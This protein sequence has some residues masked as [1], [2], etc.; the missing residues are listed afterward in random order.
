MAR[1]K[2]TQKPSAKKPTT[3]RAQSNFFKDHPHWSA[4][5]IL[6]V[7]LLIF[8]YPIVFEGK[9]LVQPDSLTSKSYQTFINDALKSGSY[10][11]WNPYIFSGMPSFGSFL[12]PLINVVDT[13]INYV[14]KGMSA[15][16]P[17][18]PFMRIILNYVFFG[19]LTYLLMLSL[20]VNR[21]AALFA[22]ISMMFLPQ[23]VAF[24]SY[25]HNSKFLSV[26]V[27]P[28]IFWAVN[29]MLVKKNLFYFVLT[30]FAIGFQ[31]LRTHVQ[32]CYYTYMFI[33]LYMIVHFIVEYKETKQVSNILKGLGLMAGSALVALLMAS[34]LYLSVYEYSH[35]SIRG[36]GAEG[37]LSYDYASSWSFSPAEVITFFVPSFFGFGGSA[38]YWGKMP[39]TDYP[40]YAGI[41]VLFLA[42][43]A[44]VLKRDRYAIFLTIVAALS[45]I[46]SFGKHFPILYDPMFKLLPFFNK[47]RVPSM[48][49]I[50]LDF[51]LVLLAALG[52]QQLFNLRES[53][54]QK[55]AK[56]RA[57]SD[58]VSK[59]ILKGEG[60]NQTITYKKPSYSKL[61]DKKTE[62]VRKYF[63]IFGAV[64]IVITLFIILGKSTMLG[65]MADSGKGLNPA[66][67]MR[68]YEM[69]LTDAVK[70]L[71]LVG[72][73]GFAILHYVQGKMKSGLLALTI[74]VLAIADFWI[75]DFN[76]VDPKSA[77][78]EE[79]YFR[80]TAAVQYLEN[81]PGPF[82][83]FSAVDEKPA[84]WYMY[85]RIQNVSGYHAAKLRI[86][87]EFLEETGLDGNVRLPY[88]G[89]PI[90]FFLSK[91]YK[92][93][94]QDGQ[95]SIQI[96]LP[97]DIPEDRI[98]TDNN[99]LKMLNVRYITSLYPLS[100]P[101]YQLVLRSQPL[102]Y[103]N[104]SSLPRAFF[105]NEIKTIRGKE[106]I[107][108]Y[109]KSAEFDPARVAVLEEEPPFVIGPVADNTVELTSF[110]IHTIKLKA[111]AAAPSLLVLSEIYYPKGWKAYVDGKE[112]KIFKTDY[113]LRSIF[114]TP[115]QHEI[116]FVFKPASFRI[117]LII[118]LMT[119]IAL[120][121]AFIFS[122]KKMKIKSN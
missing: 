114:L 45:L 59:I 1:I 10:P 42:G 25:G 60:L 106:D 80:K 75:V 51:S 39:F 96:V 113:I 76:I 73:C 115:G 55:V 91:Y 48:I 65:W 19:M 111:N 4:A 43:L 81:Q 37:G 77:V 97:Q 79:A 41:I 98:R 103:Q 23:F 27:I 28:L 83:I 30:A 87:Q 122:V 118:S 109:M 68:A 32:V 26:V 101:N 8:Y 89:Q 72:L 24:T 63:Y 54:D 74:I 84:N 90:P 14:L 108:N 36:G 61:A 105:V 35:F 71:I 104:N 107:F 34:V 82:R 12:A 85:H 40:L 2:K 5:I 13:I 94:L 121:A 64:G 56:N 33:G 119:S 95:P 15:V 20:N 78:N 53:S 44:L 18:T 117:G 66:G 120:V 100:E 22:A 102:V 70:M 62:L 116:E 49:H 52:L 88:S 7:L 86:Y 11:L 17:L 6:F 69:A 3:H 58:G 57:D 29:R 112:T 16:L 92:E 38:T 46:I 21:L 99:W 110:D 9:T 50:L 67:Q 93:V 47:F 31:L